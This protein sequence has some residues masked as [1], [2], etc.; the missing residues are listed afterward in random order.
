MAGPLQIFSGLDQNGDSQGFHTNYESGGGGYDPNDPQ[1][2]VQVGPHGELGDWISGARDL[3]GRLT[4]GTQ[5]PLSGPLSGLDRGG[6]PVNL[7]GTDYSRIGLDPKYLIGAAD[8]IGVKLDPQTRAYLSDPANAKYDNTLGYLMPTSTFDP[9]RNQFGKV[10]STIHEKDNSSLVA[11]LSALG[12]F[13]G[14]IIGATA[15][16]AGAGAEGA[17]GAAEFNPIFGS[18]YSDAM[19]GVGAFADGAGS[20][21]G[22]G[23]ESFP[24]GDVGPVEGSPLGEMSQGIP[25]ASSRVA[26]SFEQAPDLASDAFTAPTD[27]DYLA[28][29][30]AQLQDIENGASRVTE[31]PLADWSQGL[32]SPWDTITN[33]LTDI[34]G[35][36]L[37]SFAN[38]PIG[39]GLKA[40]T[41]AASLGKALGGPNSNAASQNA[42]AAAAAANAQHSMSLAPVT[43]LSRSRQPVN[44]TK[45]YAMG[46]EQLFYDRPAGFA[47]GGPLGGLAQASR[48]SRYIAGDSGG[49]DDDVIIHAS[50]GEFVFDAA[51]TAMAGDGNNAAGAKKFEELRQHIRKHA[52]MKARGLPPKQPS[53]LAYLKKV[54][55]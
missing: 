27:A 40:L 37:K 14:P 26:G 50:P 15:G 9:L 3:S 43:P 34:P 41:L 19:N 1:M 25:D 31:G 45:R 2:I 22:A 42:A 36:V 23:A 55:S 46:P 8:K 39:A 29:Q 4:W 20:A 16:A 21:F 53:A 24:L 52:G 51:T 44:V 30:Q 5:G 54:K 6:A 11:F 17:M 12:M 49:Q 10:Q 32:Q 48:P 33:K 7:E 28:Q 18:A 47:K 35:N 38:D 13:A